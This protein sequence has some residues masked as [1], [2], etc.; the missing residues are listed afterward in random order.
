MAIKRAS[1]DFGS[2]TLGLTPEFFTL[3]VR[4]Q[5]RLAGWYNGCPVVEKLIAPGSRGAEAMLERYETLNF[6]YGYIGREIAQAN[7]RL[8]TELV[9]PIRRKADETPGHYETESVPRYYNGEMPP[10]GKLVGYALPRLFVKQLCSGGPGRQSQQR[11]MNEGLDQLATIIPAARTPEQL[12]VSFAEAI[13]PEQVS[14]AEVLSTILSETWYKEHNSKDMIA[15]IKRTMPKHAPRLW[16]A[17]KSM[18]KVQ[19]SE[20]KI[21]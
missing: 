2:G 4:D 12:L 6:W 5:A 10:M 21:V 14:P 9:R 3:P 1:V 19:K 17:Y 16:Q 13:D 7:P 11:R 8:L 18:S 15:A 20:H